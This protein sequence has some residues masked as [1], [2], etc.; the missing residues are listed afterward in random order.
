MKISRDGGSTWSNYKTGLTESA[1]LTVNGLYAGKSYVFRVYGVSSAGTTLADYGEREFA[2]VTISSD[3]PTLI[4][5]RAIKITRTAASNAVTATKWYHVTPNGDVEIVSAR[6]KLSYTPTAATYDVK[7]VVRGSGSS[8][9]CVATLTFASPITVVYNPST[10]QA[11]LTWN[12]IFDAA[13]YTLK[14]SKDDGLT[15]LNYKTGLTSCATTVNGLYV[16]KTYGF[17]VYGVDAS[18]TTLEVCYEKTFIPES[19]SSAILE[20]AFADFFDDELFED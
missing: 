10:R 3:S 19:E 8:A 16:G 18:G 20:E 2:P 11:T 1:S 5:G 17:R 9:G 14:I 13:K 4:V 12:A 7:V 6:G 15:W